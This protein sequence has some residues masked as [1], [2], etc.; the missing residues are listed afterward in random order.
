MATNPYELT[1]REV[2]AIIFKKK[3]TLAVVS[4]S[5]FVLVFGFSYIITPTYRA[6]TRILV[7]SGQEFQVRSDPGEP[8]AS[9]PYATKQ[10]IVNSEIQILTSRD[11]IEAVIDRIGLAKLYPRIAENPPSDQRP[12][13]A[14]VKEFLADF[15]PVP[16]EQ[17]DV[18]DASYLNSDRD[19]AINALQ[20]L[21]QLYEEKHAQAFSSPRYQF[22]ERQTKDYE[23]QLTEVIQR[24]TQLRKD[25]SLFD[26]ETQ[27]TKLLDERTSINDI[28]QQLQSQSIDAHKRVEFLT[29]QMQAT[30]E[31]VPGGEAAAD[32]VEQ[33]KDRLLDLQVKIQQLRERYT[34]DDV[35]PLDD[36]RQ[37]AAGLKRFIASPGGMN[38][39]QWSQRNPAY[40]ELT[41]ALER[42]GA[43]AAPLDAQIALRTRELAAVDAQLRNLEDGSQKLK[44]LEREQRLLDEL[45]HT[46]R[47]RYED[48]RISEDYAA[49]RAVSVAVIEPADASAK[50]A[51]PSHLLFA[52]AGIAI[53]ALGA[54]MILVYYLVFR[55]S[56]ITVESVERI[57]GIPVLTSVPNRSRA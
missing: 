54:L 41:V 46:Y 6:S 56:L 38:R 7:K 22:L 23:M 43:D 3:W 34:T 25:Q 10:E 12:I 45:V 4:V 31:L 39:K 15:S 2:L 40:D 50:P 36:A 19:L 24:I 53:A 29:A 5:L 47:T 14:A 35:K 49:H 8:V 20:A 44:E 37:E 30:P 55:S 52:L 32:A 18:I 13:D 11:L 48:A 51:K 33:A 27:R 21:V 9:V 57:V 28:L 16:V 17:A 1:T 42:A 26:V